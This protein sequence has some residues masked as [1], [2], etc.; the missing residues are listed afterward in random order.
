M[1]QRQSRLTS[2]FKLSTCLAATLA[3]AIAA[4]SQEPDL[5]GPLPL[6]SSTKAD[7]FPPEWM[8][9]PILAK[10]AP[11]DKEETD[12]SLAMAKKAVKKYPETV[13]KNNLKKVFL[14][15]SLNFFGQP[16]GG[17]NSLDTIY[18]CNDGKRRGYTDAYLEQCFHHEFSSILLRNF[19]TIFPAK[20]WTEANP[21]DFKYLGDGLMALQQ[22][23]S[24]IVYNPELYAKG[25]LTTYSQASVEEDF[26]MIVEGMFSGNPAFWQA[27]DSSPKLKAKCTIAIDFYHRL[28]SWFTEDKFRS[29]VERAP[30]LRTSSV[31]RIEVAR[32]YAVR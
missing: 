15:K 5:T 9:K 21:K 31:P 19:P 24:S 12:R 7:M 27:I 8:E 13:L 20:K 30:G 29:F 14:V 17:T 3:I 18:L 32:V 6:Y 26:N 1:G 2:F 16:Y 23:K 22:S 4:F 11:L 28:D 10:A 25:F